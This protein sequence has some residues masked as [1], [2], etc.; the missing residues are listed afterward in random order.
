MV[1]RLQGEVAELVQ[2]VV[3][4]CQGKVSEHLQVSGC[5]VRLRCQNICR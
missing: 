3:V 1:E 4:G 5:Q 2:G